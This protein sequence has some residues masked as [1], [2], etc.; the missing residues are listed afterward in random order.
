MI[1]LKRHIQLILIFL[2]LV[3]AGLF[4]FLFMAEN[5]ENKAKS[6]S[7]PEMNKIVFNIQSE[8]EKIKVSEPKVQ[9]VDVEAE[10]SGAK[11]KPPEK[12]KNLDSV[13]Y[14]AEKKGEGSGFVAGDE[15]GFPA[16][17]CDENTSKDELLKSLNKLYVR[18]FIILK[19]GEAIGVVPFNSYSF[20]SFRRAI[21][22]TVEGFQ[23][24]L[25]SK[26]ADNLGIYR[27]IPFQGN[28]LQIGFYLPHKP[29]VESLKSY[30]A[31]HN[32][33]LKPEELNG[34]RCRY[35]IT[36]FEILEVY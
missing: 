29:V 23:R 3:D 36:G 31:V 25:T 30:M 12:A 22:T 4:L 34:F 1:F 17:S 9:K 6:F 8:I 10:R 14:K 21:P 19:G 2:F 26:E 5:A 28:D 7:K 27:M 32:M 15:K 24:I 13:K 35:S 20:G 18:E 33:N 11:K 16:F